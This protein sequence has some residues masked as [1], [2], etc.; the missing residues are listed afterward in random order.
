M[1]SVVR[2]PVLLLFGI[3]LAACAG[4]DQGSSTQTEARASAQAQG[5]RSVDATKAETIARDACGGVA[6]IYGPPGAA[7][8]LAVAPRIETLGGMGG[9]TTIDVYRVFVLCANGDVQ[10]FTYRDKAVPV[11]EFYR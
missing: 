7:S 5:A 4:T 2:R 6:N 1:T 8:S 10:T 3:L 9:K 11:E